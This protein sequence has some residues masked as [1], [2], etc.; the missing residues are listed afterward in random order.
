MSQNKKLW[1]GILVMIVAHVVLGQ[2]FSITN[3]NW[4]Y[5]ANAQSVLLSFIAALAGGRIAQR[6]FVLPALIT[7]AILWVAIAFLLYKIAEPAG[8]ANLLSIM[9]HN[10]VAILLTGAATAFGAFLG[11]RLAVRIGPVAAT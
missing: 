8:Q 11:E 3:D 6:Q 4:F 5:H 10:W 9:E 1:L 7:L 2:L